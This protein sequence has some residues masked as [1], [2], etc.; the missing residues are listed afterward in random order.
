MTARIGALNGKDVLGLIT[1]LILGCIGVF[2][3][4]QFVDVTD[5]RAWIVLFI[6]MTLAS[7]GFEIVARV[8][9]RFK[10]KENGRA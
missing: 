5:P 4:H 1:G 2:I 10:D 6:V 3:A 9:S 8:V 7:A